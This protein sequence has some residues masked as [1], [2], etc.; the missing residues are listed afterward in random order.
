MVRCPAISAASKALWFFLE[1]YADRDGTNAF[2]SHNT[3]M[4]EMGC[5]GK[6]VDAHLKE[7]KEWGLISVQGKQVG[8]GWPVNLYTLHAPLKRGHIMCPLKDGSHVPPKRGHH[9]IPL[10]ITKTSPPNVIP[11]PQARKKRKPP[12]EEQG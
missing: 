8:A 9:H 11:M 7:L 10:P 6:W 4:R 2:P 5:K 12:N 3:I 1:S